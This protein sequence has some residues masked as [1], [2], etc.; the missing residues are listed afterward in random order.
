VTTNTDANRVQNANL[1]DAFGGEAVAMGNGLFAVSGTLLNGSPVIDEVNVNNPSALVVTPVAAATDV[2]RMAVSGSQLYATSISGLL[3]YTTQT[4][5][6]TSNVAALPATQSAPTFKVSWSGSDGGGPGISTYS[7]YVSD[8]GGPFVA[9]ITKTN[10]TSATFSGQFGHS[11]G[12][13]SV[14]TDALGLVQPTPS[15]AQA[16]T[17]VNAAPP[18]VVNVMG[19]VKCSNAKHQI[20]AISVTFTHAVNSRE[21][22]STGTYH[23]VSAGT[24]GSFTAKNASVIKLKR[25]VYTSSTDSVTLMPSKPVGLTKPVELII[26]GSGPSGL[27]DSY[28]QYIDGDHNGVAGGNAVVVL[29][30][31]GAK[32][33][34]VP[35][36]QKPARTEWSPSKRR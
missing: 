36:A 20:V 17:K 3:V 33:Q 24:G 31:S 29:A 32:I 5:N 22:D 18:S 34:A 35:L 11:Y 10:Q 27:R 9:W 2:H 16:S 7:I 8:N 4:G 15:T 1:S 14:A 25:A 19:V 30:G 6:P 13:Y 28:G 21:A 23:L 26:Y 12:F